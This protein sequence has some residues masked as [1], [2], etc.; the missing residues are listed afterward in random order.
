[1]TGG[2]EIVLSLD[3]AL[4]TTGYA[5]FHGDE[6]VANGTFTVPSD[7]PMDERLHLFMLEVQKLKRQYEPDVICFEDIQDQNNTKTFKILAYVQA[8]MLIFCALTESKY[9][10][11]APSHWRKVLGGGFGRTRAEQKEHSIAIVKERFG[12]DV[13]SDTADAICIGL[14]HLEESKLCSQS[15]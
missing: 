8:S 1:M 12:I 6:L 7:K 10:I 13:D 11:L 5:V 15:Q 14:A 4:R 3:Q 9:C 2:T